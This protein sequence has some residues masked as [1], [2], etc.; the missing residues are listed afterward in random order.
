MVFKRRGHLNE[1]T[2]EFA[3]EHIL[4]ISGSI[5]WGEEVANGNVEYILGE[6]VSIRI[7]F[8]ESVA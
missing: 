5:S 7:S 8:W 2:R 6:E 4:I 1:G 3:F